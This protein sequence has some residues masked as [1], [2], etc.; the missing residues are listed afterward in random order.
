MT[1]G[2]AYRGG[3]LHAEGVALPE[4]AKAVGTPFYCYSSATLEDRYR[5]F[6]GAFA[7]MK[8]TVCF[9]LKANSSLAVVK[10]FAVLGA[11]A[12]VVSGGEM[13]I[14]LAAGIDPKRI[15]FSGVGKTRA[16]MAAALQAGIGQFNVESEAELR[17]LSEVAVARRTKA[18]I[19]IRINPDVDAHTHEKITT[20]RATDKFGIDIARA[21]DAYALARSLKGIETVGVA[22]HIGSQILD[23][24]PFRAAFARITELARELGGIARMDL[25]GGLGIAYDGGAAPD[26]TDYA[27][28]VREATKGFTGELV[29][30]PGRYLAADAGVLVAAVLYIKDSGPKRFVIVDAAM[31]DLIRPALYGAHHE[32]VA[33][34]E[35][36]ANAPLAEADV[37]GPVCE[38]GDVLGAARALPPLGEGALIAV[39]SAGAYGATMASEYNSRPLVPEVMVHGATYAVIRP[40][41]SREAMLARE[42]LPPWLADAGAA[43][44]KTRA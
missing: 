7:G 37:V 10:T 34:A 39:K 36:A 3:V 13:L 29:F 8:A 18:P 32:I 12:D 26:P 40:R 5:K 33:V 16:E 25:G 9:A 43:R 30:E 1:T 11:G 20:G 38:S 22:V 28:V 14:A 44:R 17:V 4:I 23:L 15:V 27:A 21:R 6:S 19:A 24:A 31:N 35:P 2:F 41:P 42:A